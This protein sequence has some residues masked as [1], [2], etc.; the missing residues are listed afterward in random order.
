MNRLEINPNNEKYYSK[1]FMQ[2]YKCGTKSQHDADMKVLEHIKTEIAE[3]PE[4]MG[5]ITNIRSGEITGKYISSIKVLQI[6]DKYKA[7]RR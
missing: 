5:T 7:E 6:I 2:G 4:D 1:E 3:L